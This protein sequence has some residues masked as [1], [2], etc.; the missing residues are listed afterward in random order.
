MTTTMRLSVPAPKTIPSTLLCVPPSIT[1][2]ATLKMMTTSRFYIRSIHLRPFGIPPLQHSLL[3]HHRMRSHQYSHRPRPLGV[4]SYPSRLRRLPKTSCSVF[5][6]AEHLNYHL[7]PCPTM[8]AGFPFPLGH[9]SSS[10]PPQ[11]PLPAGTYGHPLP[12]KES[13]RSGDRQPR[14]L[15]HS[16]SVPK[17]SSN[18]PRRTSAS[19]PHRSR[20]RG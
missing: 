19:F 4:R 5:L 15:Q 11:R 6:V 12:V 13:A 18:D 16:Q 9:P 8:P 1:G 7:R 20:G 10:V 3:S 2:M 17:R 14:T